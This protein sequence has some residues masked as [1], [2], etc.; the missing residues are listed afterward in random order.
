MEWAGSERHSCCKRDLYFEDGAGSE[1]SKPKNPAYPLGIFMTSRERL[2][3]VL[4]GEI[5]DC[6]PV[7]PDFSNMNATTD[8]FLNL[9]PLFDFMFESQQYIDRSGDRDVA[10]MTPRDVLDLTKLHFN[11]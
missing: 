10:V 2:Q 6:V 9:I 5:P 1:V 3:T 11:L 7:A 8:N 4:R